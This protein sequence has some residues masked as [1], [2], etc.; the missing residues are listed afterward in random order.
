MIPRHPLSLKKIVLHILLIL[1]CLLT[2]Y[3]SFVS[4]ISVW[5]G[6]GYAH[7]PGFWVPIAAGTTSLIIVLCALLRTVRLL[8]GHIKEND[9]V[10]L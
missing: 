5:I 7:R 9:V 3:L 8:L 10:N 2:I 6:I 1:S 4:L